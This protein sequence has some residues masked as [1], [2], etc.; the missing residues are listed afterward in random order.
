MA[1][2]R[3]AFSSAVN[4]VPGVLAAAAPAVTATGPSYDLSGGPG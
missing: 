1:P 3:K 2:L 4:F